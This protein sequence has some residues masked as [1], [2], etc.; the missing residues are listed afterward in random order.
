M[1]IRQ[2]ILKKRKSLSEDE[3]ISLSSLICE[4]VKKI[5]IEFFGTTVFAYKSFQN[6]IETQELIEYFLSN[7]VRVCVPVII[8]HNEII[9]KTV[10]PT[11]NYCV[12]SFGILEPEM[13]DVVTMEDINTILVP[14]IAFDLDLNRIGFGKG[15]YDNFLSKCFGK[16]IALAYDFQ[17]MKSIPSED[18]DI[19]MDMIITEKRIIY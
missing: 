9:A 14:G 13:T 3:V 11:C 12:N 18:H 5:D 8:D 6:E 4:E 17:V 19:K 16:K 10:Q 1:E 7:N 15:Y 2:S